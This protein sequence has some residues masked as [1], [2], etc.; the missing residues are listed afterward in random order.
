MS[1]SSLPSFQGRNWPAMKRPTGELKQL[2]MLPRAAAIAV[3]TL[4]M[5]QNACYEALSLALKE[6][7]VFAAL[8]G[9]EGC[10]KTTVLEA[11]LA[12]RK[13]RALRCIHITDPDKVPAVLADQIEQVAYAEAG[14]PENLERHIVLAVDDAHIASHEL[15]QCLSRLAAMREPGRR[16]PQIL[17]VGRS[18]LWQRLAS[19]EYEPLARRLAIRA[20]LPAAEDD[21]DPWASVENDVSQTMAHLRAEADLRPVVMDGPDQSYERDM[22]FEPEFGFGTGA[23]GQHASEMVGEDQVP[24]PS[25]FALFPDPPSKPR[26]AARDT[27]RR[28]VMPLVSLFVG[29][30]AFAFALSFYDWPDLLGDMPWSDP[31]PTAPFVMPQSPQSQSFGLPQPPSAVKPVI[32]TAPL[33]AARP[34]PAPA[35]PIPP[36]PVASPPVASA[37]VASAPVASAPVVVPVP[38]ASARST[39]AAE[40]PAAATVAQPTAKPAEL[41]PTVATPPVPTA[42]AAPTNVQTAS[43]PPPARARVPAVADAP[44][45][46][47]MV[48][49]LL[50]RG[51][52]QFAIGD[53]SAARLFFERAAESGSGLAARQMARTFDSSFLPS[54][55]DGALADPARAREWYQ[56]AASLGNTDGASRLKALTQGR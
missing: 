2:P 20:A 47:A 42:P 27:R 23:T 34:A 46:P 12:D 39:P 19:E 33:A 7:Q 25:M 55:V 15:L 50:K 26:S 45:A 32:K 35:P 21:S 11:V 13:D 54:A 5:A 37:P 24:P 52:E 48:A 28:L 30:A 9:P 18:E 4:R 16:V 40:P 29:V 10:G 41:P 17:L 44:L 43:A 8:T 49:M 38:A 3:P 1:S 6:G 31:K 36:A 56:R 53:I 22:Q 51:D 14:K